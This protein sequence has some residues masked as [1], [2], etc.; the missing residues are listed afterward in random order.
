MSTQP[1]TLPSPSS[2]NSTDEV[3]RIAIEGM[4]GR[5]QLLLW[6]GTTALTVIGGVAALGAVFLNNRL[7]ATESR[8][9]NVV[10]EAVVPLKANE[11]QLR[12][13]VD[14]LVKK[15][16][17]LT[18]EDRQFANDVL[19]QVKYDDVKDYIQ[20]LPAQK[21]R[22]PLDRLIASKRVTQVDRVTDL[23]WSN[24]EPAQV[25]FIKSNDPSLDLTEF[26]FYSIDN[27]P[28]ESR[29]L[30]SL[31]APNISVEIC[32]THLAGEPHRLEL[33]V[34]LPS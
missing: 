2:A 33:I 17:E 5:W 15:S 21:K 12:V 29:S 30:E 13:V 22:V 31:G 10:R 32:Q 6:L 9:T 3:Q 11:A 25:R 28:C 18:P 34:V 1:P 8:L 24:G 23:T 16:R 26:D 4:P 7:E 19:K 20:N 14:F 27:D